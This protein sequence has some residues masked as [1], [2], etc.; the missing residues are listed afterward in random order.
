MSDFAEKLR[1]LVADQIISNPTSAQCEECC[2]RLID[3]VAICI[4][5]AVGDDQEEV[6][7]VL[8]V[9]KFNLHKRTARRMETVAHLA[10]E[11]VKDEEE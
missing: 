7:R 4:V 3:A 6:K 10:E 11:A 9:A 2:N 1:C 5:A 8:E